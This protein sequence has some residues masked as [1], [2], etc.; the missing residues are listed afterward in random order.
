MDF[1]AKAAAGI[2]PGHSS[3]FEEPKDHLDPNLFDG[4]R[5]KFEVR[6]KLMVMLTDGLNETLNL[7]GVDNWVHAWLAGSGITYQWECGEGDLDVLFGVEMAQFVMD[8]PVFQGIPE[9]AISEWADDLLR[10][11]LWPQTARTRFGRRIYE[12]AFYWNPGTHDHIEAIKPYA[13]YNLRTDEWTVEPPKLP[14]DP[15]MLYPHEW[16]AAAQRD[17]D[18]ASGILGPIAGWQDV[19]ATNAPDSPAGRSATSS[20]A[21]AQ[22]QAT[23][24]LEEIH[25]GRRAAFGLNGQGYGDW[26][27]FRWQHAKRDGVVRELLRITGDARADQEDNE[28]ALYGGPIEGAD[29]ILMRDMLRPRLPQ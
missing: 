6:S 20:L 22:Q 11:K 29:K 14:D 9:G 25:H 21:R 16:F 5:L 24:L 15:A 27:N 23:A 18:A 4:T 7:A 8:N 3:Y 1:Y 26:A 10:N 12:V 13:A 2:G 17:T 28:V 19:L